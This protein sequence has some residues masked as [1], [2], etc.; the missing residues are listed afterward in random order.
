MD[1]E[2]GKGN[3]VIFVGSIVSGSLATISNL[4]YLYAKSHARA[5]IQF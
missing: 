1:G 4:F 3:V 2:R 5:F